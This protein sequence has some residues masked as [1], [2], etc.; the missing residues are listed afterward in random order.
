MPQKDY[1]EAGSFSIWLKLFLSLQRLL[2][3]VLH[4]EAEGEGKAQPAL[5]CHRALLSAAAGTSRPLSEALTAARNGSRRACRE[6]GGPQ[7]LWVPAR[8]ARWGG[9]SAADGRACAYRGVVRFW[10]GVKEKVRARRSRPPSRWGSGLQSR[11]CEEA[12][13]RVPRCGA[14]CSA[15]TA[16]P[17][18][19]A[20]PVGV[21]APRRP[22]AGRP[23]R[24][25]G[26]LWAM[27]PPGS[28]SLRR[29]RR[30][31][32]LPLLVA[33]LLLLHG[34]ARSRAAAAD[35]GYGGSAGEVSAAP[36]APSRPPRLPLGRWAPIQ[37]V[38]TEW[39][40]PPP[41]TALCTCPLPRM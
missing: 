35:G 36:C 8:G 32:L 20:R 16:F 3:L 31:A 27:K 14:A 29:P 34:Y 12:D 13:G 38:A 5:R 10:G 4:L 26:A 22:P 23:P 7:G 30:P 19:R 17:A 40:L 6:G 9:G 25:L 37:R 18:P 11:R 24:R 15:H 21:R 1:K 2:I 33:P 41:F 28:I 39:A